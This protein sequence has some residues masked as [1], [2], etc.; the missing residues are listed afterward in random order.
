MPLY[1]EQEQVASAVFEAQCILFGKFTLAS[2]AK[3]PIYVDLRK[4]RSFPEQKQVV[5]DE[6]ERLLRPLEFDLLADVPTAATPLV[7]SLSDRFLAN[8]LTKPQI[9]PKLDAKDHGTGAEIDGAYSQG[10]TV[11]VVDDLITTAGSKLKAIEVLERNGLGVR[12]VVVLVDREQG[13]REGLAER[14]YDLHASVTLRDLVQFYGKEG[15]IPDS[16]MSETLEYLDQ[17]KRR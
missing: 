6:Y 16:R 14:G 2:G 11:A 13:G 15:L 8:K 12:D 1:R 17:Q 10:Q 3:S 5:V 4:I 9:T 7:S